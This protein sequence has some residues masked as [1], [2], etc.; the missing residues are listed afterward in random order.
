MHPIRVRLNYRRFLLLEVTLWEVPG[1]PRCDAD[2]QQVRV[3]VT[4]DDNSSRHR[5][6]AGSNNNNNAPT[7]KTMR[8]VVGVS[9]DPHHRQRVS[10]FLLV[11]TFEHH[12][13]ESNNGKKTRKLQI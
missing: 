13:R 8:R 2:H 10:P 6:S 4:P 1:N 12:R 7:I 11:K 5:Q 3:T 9:L